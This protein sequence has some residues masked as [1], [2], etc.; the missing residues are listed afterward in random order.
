MENDHKNAPNTD[1]TATAIFARV[2]SFLYDLVKDGERAAVILA[3]ARIDMSLEEILKSVLLP[4]SGGADDLFDTERPLSTLSSK[5]TLVHRLGLIDAD[6]ERSIQSIRKIRNEFAHSH[7]RTSLK[8]GASSNRLHEFEK[9]AR[10][11][12]P[13]EQF[14]RGFTSS[15]ENKE[16]AIF[17]ACVAVLS[18]QLEIC[19]QFAPR[20]NP[21]FQSSFGKT[22]GGL[23]SR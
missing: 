22:A 21:G 23:T 10:K 7:Q 14:F 5:I 6:V 3:A 9:L 8:D 16:L 20:Y 11:S 4:S 19:C 1:S 13:Y 2:Q 18:M 17:V 15:M 12:P